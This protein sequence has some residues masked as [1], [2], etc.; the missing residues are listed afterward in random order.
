MGGSSSM[1]V[2]LH[3]ATAQLRASIAP[4]LLLALRLTAVHDDAA[5][6]TAAERSHATAA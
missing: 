1:H 4:L 5:T 6:G 2:D 3:A